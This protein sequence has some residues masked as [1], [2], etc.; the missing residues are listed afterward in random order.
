MM[1][2][3]RM[4]LLYGKEVSFKTNQYTHQISVIGLDK[5]G[6]RWFSEYYYPTEYALK[7]DKRWDEVIRVEPECGGFIAWEMATII[8]EE[9]VYGKEK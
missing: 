3:Y 5:N 4:I 9:Y 8:I 7:N 6:A 2:A 1:S